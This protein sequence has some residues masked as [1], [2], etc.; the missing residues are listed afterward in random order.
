VVITMVAA[1]GETT[2]AAARSVTLMP[3]RSAKVLAACSSRKSAM[4]AFFIAAGSRNAYAS[5]VC[6]CEAAA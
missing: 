1:E 5:A 2:T 6:I 4:N 3:A